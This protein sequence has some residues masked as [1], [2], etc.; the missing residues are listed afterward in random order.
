M[1]KLMRMLDCEFP[2]GGDTAEFAKCTAAFAL[3]FYIFNNLSPSAC[4]CVVLVYE[5]KTMR[6]RMQIYVI[7]ARAPLRL[8][9]QTAHRARHVFGECVLLK[10]ILETRAKVYFCAILLYTNA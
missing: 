5:S 8:S 4:A 6:S 2:H 7:G 10:S 3:L 9:R 1:G